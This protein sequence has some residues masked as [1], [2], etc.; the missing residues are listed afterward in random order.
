[1]GVLKENIDAYNEAK[2][3]KVPPEILATMAQCTEELKGAGIES[4]ALRVGDT[5]PDFE[6][7]N[8]HGESR[9]LSRYLAESP[10]VLNVYRGGW[11]PY[12]NMEMKALHDVLPEI[13]A[14]GAR[15]I[16]L[17][18]ETP[19]KAMTTA[20]NNGIDIDILSDEANRVARQ[21]G[22]VF[23]LPQAL[24]PI[25]QKIGIDIPA[26]NGDDSFM[27]PVPATYIIGQDGVIL[28]DFVNADYTLRLE[29][30]EIVAILTGN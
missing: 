2:K 5:M 22:L 17:T 12:C 10:V 1:M 30:S 27:L 11:C 23:E 7:P 4:R 15:L 9:R 26:Y 16:G 28:Y 21:M 6:L 8:Q 20:E 25:Y 19:D 18:P 14:R 24:R 29:P 3:E 13:E